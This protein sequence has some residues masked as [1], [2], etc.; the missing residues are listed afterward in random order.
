MIMTLSYMY[1]GIE[2]HTAHEQ[3]TITPLGIFIGF[4]I[5]F[6]SF[7]YVD[8]RMNC[9]NDSTPSPSSEDQK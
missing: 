3:P 6:Y 2:T 9:V 7:K 1:F 8:N 4:F 5:M